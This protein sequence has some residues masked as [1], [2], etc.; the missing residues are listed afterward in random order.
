[1]DNQQIRTLGRNI[2]EAVVPWM[3]DNIVQSSPALMVSADIRYRDH[4]G[5]RKVGAKIAWNMQTTTWKQ[6]PEKNKR[7]LSLLCIIGA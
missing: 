4:S 3:I 2:A 1:M 7:V 6:S 5:V